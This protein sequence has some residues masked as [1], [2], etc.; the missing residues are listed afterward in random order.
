MKGLFGSDPHRWIP[1][2]AR[3]PLAQGLA[4]DMY[5]SLWA[6]VTCV[7]VTVL[8]TLVTRPKPDSELVGLVYSLTPLAKEEHTNFWQRPVVWGVIALI[9]LVILQIIFW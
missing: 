6:C 8:V 2:F 1:I 4:Q 7:V 3:S 9:L 5:Q